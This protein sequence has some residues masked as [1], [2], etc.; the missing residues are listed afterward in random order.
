MDHGTEAGIS[1]RTRLIG[2]LQTVSGVVAARA[3]G[4]G[5]RAACTLGV[6][7]VCSM[8]SRCTVGVESVVV[9]SYCK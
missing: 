1:C 7:V 6:S 3:G 8:R 5:R 4:Q 9:I 2:E